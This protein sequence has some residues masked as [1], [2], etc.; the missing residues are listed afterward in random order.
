VAGSSERLE[1]EF[2]MRHQDGG[3]RWML[4]NG[5]R[6][7]ERLLVG[8]SFTD[9]TAMK[10]AENQIL[11]EA[12]HDPLTGLP[13]KR[14]FLDRLGLALARRRHR[15]GHPVAVLYLD[16][17]RFHHVND[18]LGVDAGDA[19]L[20]EVAGR[21][22]QL[23]RLGDTVGRLGGDKFTILL[24]G[25]DGPEETMRF[26]EDVVAELA[27]PLR[28]AGQELCLSCSVGLTISHT[29]NERPEDLVGE[30][31]SAMHLAKD[32]GCTR[33]RLFDP[34]TNV[35]ARE[36]LLLEADL[37]HAIER[38]E[39]ML[40]YQPIVSFA[41]GGLT[42][43]EALV[44]WKHPTRGLIR[45]D[46][47]I[48]IAEQTGQIL[49]IGSWVL[50]EACRRMRTWHEQ[51]PGGS[52]VSIAVNLSARQFENESLVDEV[53]SL[54]DEAG[55]EPNE[56]HLEMTESV[57]MARTRENQLRLRALRDLGIKLLIDD[58]GTGYSSL[59]SLQG[60][61]LDALKIDRS[62][63]TGME[64]EEGK[65]EI[66]RTVL[67]LA[68]A[69]GLE[70]VAEGIETAQALNMLRELNCEQG[71]G[72]FFSSPMDGDSATAWMEN[73]PRY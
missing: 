2:R 8:G 58:F 44:R 15:P 66:V 35:H 31:V 39:L 62:F 10:K 22:T 9:V 6:H 18:S 69:L 14:L 33:F 26:A 45:P 13:N 51:F 38:G 17:D 25:I 48:P 16:L 34:E 11:L 70:V 24:D 32:D 61:A 4:C 67:A 43:F 28:L 7:P 72:Y 68:R 50:K 47:F 73:P 56:L 5:V 52:G 42:S 63:V 71:Q 19:L 3:W 53:S 21:L 46:V 57:I 55:L 20:V 64:F 54:L 65:A 60:F 37:R 36:R 1:V 59:A 49:S 27:R 41:S 40:H 29:G 12:F 23:L 30:A